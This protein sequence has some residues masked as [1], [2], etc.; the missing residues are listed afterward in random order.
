MSRVPATILSVLC[1]ASFTCCVARAQVADF[2]AAE[3]ELN[4]VFDRPDGAP[5]GDEQKQKLAAFVKRYEGQDLGRLGYAR[6]LEFYFRRDA[7]G[8][9]AALDEFFAE[10]DRIAHAEHVT[11]AGRIYLMAMREES[12]KPKADAAKLNRWAERTAAMYPDLAAVARVAA[13]IAPGIADAAPFRMALVRGMQRSGGSDQDRDRFL[14]IL[15]APAPAGAAGAGAPAIDVVMPS[16]LT[17]RSAPTLTRATV[18][19]EAGD[20]SGKL[21]VGGA[22][23]GLPVE[24]ALHTAKEFRL[25]DLR[26]KVVVLD[27]FATWSSPCRTGI[28]D[29]QKMQQ[30]NAES[31]RVVGVTRFYGRGTDFTQGDKVPDGGK[32][33][34]GLGHDEEVAVDTRFASTFGITW[35]ILFTTEKTMSE[36]FGVVDLPTRVV[37][38]KSGVVLARI[39]GSGDEERRKLRA[40]LEQAIR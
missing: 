28:A 39:V 38:D 33:V 10:H 11:M 5:I 31:V 40:L 37:L 29:L 19:K 22:A 25:A 4:S 26:G 16:P 23:P 6:A 12:Q 21:R 35:P 9:S 2:A 1:V 13:N 8:G 32:S 15:Y 20:G 14:S 17:I 30:E 24:H 34:D 18:G 36:D 7:L 27:F 3:R